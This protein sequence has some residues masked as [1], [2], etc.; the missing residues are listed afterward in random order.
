MRRIETR[1]EGGELKMEMQ[2]EDDVS[3][4]LHLQFSI[5]AQAFAA[6]ASFFQ[7]RLGALVTRPFLRALAATRT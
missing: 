3:A 5:L 2:M 7:V 1:M 4:I 6:G